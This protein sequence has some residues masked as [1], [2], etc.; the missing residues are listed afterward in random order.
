MTPACPNLPAL[1]F[2]GLGALG[3]P[4]AANLLKAGF[5]LHVHNRTAAAA[6]PLLAAG[7]QWAATPAAAA[8]TAEV[9]CLCLSDDAAVTT[10][11]NAARPGLRAGALVIDFSTISPSTSQAVAAELAQGGVRYLDAPVTGGTEGARAGTLSV[12]VGAD[13][14]DLARA[15][16]VLELVGSHISHLGPVGSGQQAKAVNQVLVAGSYGAVAEAL[17]LGQQLGLPMDTLLAALRPGAAGSWALQHRAD[18]MLAR[19]YPLGFKL[20]LHRKDLAIA[21]A[22]AQAQGVALPLSERIAAI[23]D[24]LIAAG[25]GD[26]DVS[27]LAEWFRA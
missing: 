26:A 9:L 12:L 27:A 18:A 6:E 4:M 8:A 1:A 22:A 5:A 19:T 20:S 25:L 7:A 16:P 10:V 3:R 23:E 14:A 24:A 13:A 21:L 2:I 11:L 17:S 15:R